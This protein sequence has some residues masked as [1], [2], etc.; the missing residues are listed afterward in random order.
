[1]DARAQTAIMDPR[2]HPLLVVLHWALAFF[3]IAALALGAL[4]MAP[5]ANTNPMKLAAL[6]AHMTGGIVILALMSLRLLI[7]RVTMH[8]PQAMTGTPLLDRLARFSHAAFYGAVIAMA[9]SGLIMGVQTGVIRLLAGGQSPIPPD[10]WAFPIRTVHYVT[11]RVLMGLIALHLAG[12]VYHTFICRDRLLRRMGF[13]MRTLERISPWLT[14]V[15]LLFAAFLLSMI[16]RKYISDPVAAVRDSGIVLS[17]PMALTTVRAS[18]GAFS[19]ACG[20]VAMVCLVSR[21]RNRFG[22]WF[23]ALVIGVVLAVR[24]YGIIEDGTLRENQRVLTAELA[25]F[26]M[27]VVALLIGHAVTRSAERAGARP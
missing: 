5:I 10:F 14:R 26:S 18:F 24:V 8:P 27:T 25:L 21:H 12:V 16:G 13:P 19:L 15:V 1:M 23:I 11:S 20:T 7:R 17:T 3:I 9:L 6:R 22:L 2:Y 4:K